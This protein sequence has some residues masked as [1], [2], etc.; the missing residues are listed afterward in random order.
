M[1]TTTM[2][3]FLISAVIF[4][5]A[6]HTISSYHKLFNGNFDIDGMPAMMRF[7]TFAAVLG[8]LVA[9]AGVAARLLDRKAWF[10][11]SLVADTVV[12][13]CFVGGACVSCARRCW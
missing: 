9:L 11:A 7:A 8:L 13:L 10:L 2:G 12:A 3:Q 4:S 5:L 1:L 6:V